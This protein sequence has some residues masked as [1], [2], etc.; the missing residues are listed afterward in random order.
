MR[1]FPGES[2]SR[3]R[4]VSSAVDDR[5]GGAHEGDDDPV[6]RQEAAQEISS[7]VS[8][9]SAARGCRA[10]VRQSRTACSR[11]AGSGAKAG[12][13]YRAAPRTPVQALP[14]KPLCSLVAGHPQPPAGLGW[15][16]PGCS[17]PARAARRAPR[18]RRTPAPPPSAS[19]P[20]RR[21]ARWRRGAR[22]RRGPRRRRAAGPPARRPSA[23]CESASRRGASSCGMRR[24]RIASS[25][26][27][28]SIASRTCSRSRAA[29]AR[30]RRRSAGRAP[31][32]PARRDSGARSPPGRSCRSS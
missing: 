4:V 16:G 29:A 2:A 8:I 32:L 23:G 19:R 1:S 5:T 18:P 30:R 9:C 6:V 3:E 26:R 21:S 10:H 14:R 13:V 31:S 11:S 15:P 24:S 20:S 27:A 25:A 28:A 22:P 17:G 7:A 12:G